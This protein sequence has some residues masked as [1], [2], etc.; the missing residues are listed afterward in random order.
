MHLAFRAP[1]HR[2]TVLIHAPQHR[3][4]TKEFICEKHMIHSKAEENI[5]L[6]DQTASQCQDAVWK[7]A[8]PHDST[9]P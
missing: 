5:T 6:Q 9:I 8:C 1:C 2:G 3:I 7:A 4:Q